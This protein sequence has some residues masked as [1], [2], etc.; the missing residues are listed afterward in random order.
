MW[1][2]S[3]HLSMNAAGVTQ[4]GHPGPLIRWIFGEIRL[5]IAPL[6]IAAVWVPQTSI[7][8]ISGPS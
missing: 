5:R 4:T 6:K 3:T 2:Y 7:R 8:R 1:A